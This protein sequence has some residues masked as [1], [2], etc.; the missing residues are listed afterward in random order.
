MKKCFQLPDPF[1]LT[2]KI[3]PFV[4][5]EDHLLLACKRY[6]PAL[7]EI[8]K[9]FE[10]VVNAEIQDLIHE[11][12]IIGRLSDH[13]SGRKQVPD[14]HIFNI[15]FM[16]QEQHLLLHA[17]RCQYVNRPDIQQ[18]ILPSFPGL[19]LCRVRAHKISSDP[20]LIPELLALLQ[21]TEQFLFFALI[22]FEFTPHNTPLFPELRRRHSEFRLEYL[23]QCGR[24]REA[25]VHCDPCD[26]VVCLLEVSFDMCYSHIFDI[27]GKLLA[28]NFLKQPGYG[29][30]REI[31][32][33]RHFIEL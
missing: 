2:F 30:D 13:H 23:I 10:P 3:C 33:L 19:R 14:T 6:Y 7:R 22:L 15:Q 16:G 18:A 20:L 32:M 11:S 28:G 9:D 27:N 1:P 31:Q 25:V 26:R 17:G 4:T 8:Q 29:R 21:N 5:A 24:S 12:K